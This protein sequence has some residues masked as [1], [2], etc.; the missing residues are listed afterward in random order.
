MTSTSKSA[1]SGGGS[2]VGAIDIGTNSVLLLIAERRGDELVPLLERA[3]ITRLGQD[4]DR[5]RELAPEAVERT[6]DCLAGYAADLRAR[7]V[8]HARA[9]GTSAMRD[10][11]GGQG[12][13]ERA[14]ALLGFE[15]EVI[16][17]DEEARLSFVGG[18]SGLPIAVG[19]AAV[20]FDIGGGSTEIVRGRRG[21]PRLD[22]AKSLDIGSVRLTE[23]HVRR[24]PPAPEELASIDSDVSVALAGAPR[25][26]GARLVGVAGTIT[27][28]AAIA[29]AIEP[30]DAERVHGLELRLEELE[31]VAERLAS[32]PLAERTKLPGLSPKRADVIVAGARIA[33]AVARASGAASLLVSDRGVRWGVAEA[34]STER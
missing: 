20:V 11:R 29:R 19:E 26:E 12:F 5:T 10:A 1:T 13:R 17:G 7:G 16:S 14:A 32:L 3:T 8:E 15:P 30:Y 27:T 4:V 21:E 18:L 2:R 9:V 28:L 6:L 23:R 34:L 31:E 25:I 24:D 22:A 33:V